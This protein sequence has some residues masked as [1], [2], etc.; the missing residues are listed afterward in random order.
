[1]YED[2]MYR[3]RYIWNRRKAEVNIQN[4]DGIRFENAVTVFE[5]P[6]NVEEYD[7]ENSV[8]E[9]RY[10]TTGFVEGFLFWLPSPL[11]LRGEFCRIFSARKADSEEIGAYHENLNDCIGER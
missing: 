10:N 2:V 3:G 11:L 8:Y 4:H 9:E 7:D 1:M 5:D 6:Y